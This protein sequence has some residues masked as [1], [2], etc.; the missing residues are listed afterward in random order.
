MNN[1]FESSEK[2][3]IGAGYLY[4]FREKGTPLNYYFR[5]TNNTYSIPFNLFFNE[6]KKNFGYPEQNQRL[7]EKNDFEEIESVW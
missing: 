7:E 3:S 5:I 4:I 1:V 6:M 2:L